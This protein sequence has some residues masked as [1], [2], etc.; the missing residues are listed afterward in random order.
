MATSLKKTKGFWYAVTVIAAFVCISI[1]APLIANSRPLIHIAPQGGVYFPALIDYPEFRERDFRSD[2]PEAGWSLFPPVRYSYTEYDLDSIVTPPSAK[3]LLGTDEQGRDIAAR[4]VH[5]SRNSFVI[6]FFAVMIY[7]LIGIVI[8]A[9]AGYFGGIVDIVISR[10]IEIMICFPLFFLLLALIAFL[11]QSIITIMLVIGLTGWTGTAR[12]VR[13]EFLKLVNSPI[14]TGAKSIGAGHLRI[15]FRHLLPNAL[16][17]VLVTAT[18]GFGGAILAESALSFLGFGI[19]PPEP[20]WG[21]ILAQSRDFMDFAWWLAIIP[22]GAIFL[23]ISAYNSLGR[24]IQNRH[25]TN[26]R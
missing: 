11:G 25:E 19:Q 15:I 4:M 8:G 13:G 5:G 20:S 23:V 16:P 12:I 14:V 18:F 9:L 10:I 2:T 22:G 1:L 26:S 17:P 3:H 21:D 7:V 6:S 24:Y